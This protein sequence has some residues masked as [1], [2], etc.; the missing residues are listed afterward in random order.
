MEE[1]HRRIQRVLLPGQIIANSNPTNE[2]VLYLRG[3]TQRLSDVF[4]AALDD[5]KRNTRAS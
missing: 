1:T 5:G 2:K 3:A 4:V